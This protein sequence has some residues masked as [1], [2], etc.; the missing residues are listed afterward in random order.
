MLH[1]RVRTWPRLAKVAISP[2]MI[3]EKQETG[4]Q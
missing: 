1:A 4:Y 3:G 2:H